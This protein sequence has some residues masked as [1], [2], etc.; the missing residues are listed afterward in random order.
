MSNE[1]ERESMVRKLHEFLR[2]NHLILSAD[3]SSGAP[4][5]LLEHYN[6]GLQ[7]YV[8][9]RVTGVTNDRGE[10]WNNPGY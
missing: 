4:N 10:V 7:V 2:N 8:G 1:I 3:T 9:R 5:I 6:L